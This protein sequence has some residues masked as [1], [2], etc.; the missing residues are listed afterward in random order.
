M[1][2][3]AYADESFSDIITINRAKL[4][5]WVMVGITAGV[6]SEQWTAELYVDN[7]FDE[8]AELAKNF[9]NDRERVTYSRPRTGGVR[10]SYNF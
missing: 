3:V 2:H 5:S 8:R 9:V 1:P 4:D 6:S 7:L 10:L